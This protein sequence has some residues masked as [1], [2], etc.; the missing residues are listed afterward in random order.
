MTTY[1]PNPADMIEKIM[2]TARAA[3]PDSLS[4]EM[5]EHV[6]AAL[7]DIIA[8]LDVVTREELDIQKE[9]LNKT[10]AKVDEMTQIIAELESRLEQK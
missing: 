8:D 10:R 9:V 2:Q 1:P 3:M 5:R 7:T 4:D 6:R